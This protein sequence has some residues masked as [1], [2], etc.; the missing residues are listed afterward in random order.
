MCGYISRVISVM[1]GYIYRV[2]TVVCGYIYRVVSVGIQCVS[3]SIS[4]CGGSYVQT[5][6]FASLSLNL[7]APECEGQ[8]CLT[9][10]GCIYRLDSV[11][12]VAPSDTCI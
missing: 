9:T 7:I 10:H 11:G 6:S 5:F 12:C 1:C 4:T 8:S 3:S 2:V